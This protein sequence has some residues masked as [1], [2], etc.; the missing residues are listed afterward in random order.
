[1][2]K[3]F[4][5]FLVPWPRQSRRTSLS[6]PYHTLSFPRGPRLRAKGHQWVGLFSFFH[7]NPCDKF[8]LL[9]L[10]FC[11][12]IGPPRN[13]ELPRFV[14]KSP[15][16]ERPML[17]PPPLSPCVPWPSEVFSSLGK[18]DLGHPFPSSDV[19]YFWPR[20]PPCFPPSPRYQPHSL[21]FLPQNP[22]E[23]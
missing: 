8:P 14:A 3:R 5:F 17:L 19:I 7:H 6:K 11:I 13:K 16:A 9:R 4:P 18:G 10:C 12:R 15:L 2:S 22:T 21:Q 1:V 20:R 23:T